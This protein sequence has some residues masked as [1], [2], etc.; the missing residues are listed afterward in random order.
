MRTTIIALFLCA[1]VIQSSWSQANDGNHRNFPL[2]ISIEFHSLSLPF[3]NKKN[4]FKNI[5]IGL[6][7]EVSHNGNRNWVQQFKMTWYGNKSVG[8][9]LLLHTQ[10][11]WRPDV[12]NDA[13]SE[14]KLGVGY[15]YAKRPKEGYRP[16]KSGW[17]S[18]GKKGKGMLVIPVG[19]GLGYDT[20]DAGTYVSPFA[21][22]QFLLATNYNESMPVVPFTLLEFGSRIHF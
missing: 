9:G 10:A 22:Y 21:N 5:G 4:L 17:K 1:I 8:G 11:V 16:T 2:I 6:G 13:F 7:T 18:A 3:K 15:L 20:Y 12:V 14:I 19:I